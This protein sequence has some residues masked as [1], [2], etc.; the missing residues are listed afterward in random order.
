MMRKRTPSIKTKLMTA[1]MGTS[2]IVL[3]AASAAF[4]SYEVITFRRNLVRGLATR[5][6]L[7]AANTTAALAFQNRD[8]ATHVLASLK[9]DPRMDLA[10]LYDADGKLF[11]RYPSNAP[12]RMFPVRPGSGYKFENNAFIIFVPVTQAGRQLGTVYLQ[13]NLA[14]LAERYRAYTIVVVAIIIG[15]M[16]IAFALS[17][18]AQKRIAEPVLTLA[19]KARTVSQSG[20]YSLRAETTSTDEIGVLAESFNSMLDE[21]QRRDAGL[22]QSEAR[23]RATIDSALDG[24]VTVDQHGRILELNPAAEHLFGCAKN[25]LL[26]RDVAM[27][28]PPA[29]RQQVREYFAGAGTPRGTRQE[30][31]A[32]RANGQ[33]FPVEL[34]IT[35]I[36]TDAGPIFTV[37]VHDVTERKRAE[38]VM[39]LLAAVVQSSDDA[40]ITKDLNSIILSWNQGAE[41]VFG[42]PATEALGRS[43]MF[44]IPDDRRQEEA[45]IISR[46]LR[47]E[48][49]A[50]FDTQRLRKDG[51]L[52]DVSVSVSPIREGGRII[53]A[54]NISRDIT[55][56][57]RT[58]QE[59]LKLN[60]ELERRVLDR[61]AQLEASN[62]E[63]EAFSYSVSHDLRAPL[64][65][66]DGFSMTLLEDYGSKL[67]AQARHQLERVRLGARRMG[68]LI[69]DLLKLSR[70][71][72]A[73]IRREQVNLSALARQVA[74]ELKQAEPERKVTFV[75]E[76]DVKVQGDAQLMFV[77]MDNLLRNSWKYTSRHPTARIE[78]GR[79]RQNEERVYFVRDDGAGFDMAHANL[80]FS[81]F[82][83]LHRQTDFEGTGIG[84]AT[85]QR[86]IRRHGGRTWA[87]ASVEQGAAIYFTLPA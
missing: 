55:E 76:D 86:I 36:E 24:I 39:G 69:D 37:F 40:I 83:R 71:S 32:L 46:I 47:G 35:R 17:K 2:L 41:R 6:E 51:T 11:A 60:L 45:D 80:L 25:D 19:A 48:S 33:E 14:I 34:S 82:Q 28:V 44:L 3:F 54:S 31:R 58:E 26:G 8:D 1:V 62:K 75:I 56:R 13:F 12:P 73:E 59:I 30:L 65:A 87:E 64:R 53:G 22:R 78:F 63:L 16:S 38:S 52:L 15:S 72:R 57:K 10:S 74:A 43:I 21:V 50:H 81:P 79:I 7:V 84:L 68:E 67:D 42:Y 23:T 9:S 77:V 20:N 27:L 61:T 18:W 5:A 4:I 29:L 49:M 66:I 85:V 70:V